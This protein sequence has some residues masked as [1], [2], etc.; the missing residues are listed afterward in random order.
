MAADAIV[1]EGYSSLDVS[2]L[3]GDDVPVAVGPGRPVACGSINTGD[4]FVA[5]VA[6][7]GAQTGLAQAVRTAERAHTEQSTL[8]R[9]ADR[10]VALIVVAAVVLA[11]ITLLAWLS[12]SG[13]VRDAIFAATAVLLVAAPGALA[14]SVSTPMRVG[15]GRGI[16][17]GIVI[18]RFSAV[19]NSRRVDAVVADRSLE[20]NEPT[21]GALSRHLR[22]IQVESIFMGRAGMDEAIRQ[23]RARRFCVALALDVSGRVPPEGTI[24]AQAAVGVAVGAGTFGPV[25]GADITLARRDLGAVADGFAL[26]QRIW[27]TISGNL[28]FTGVYHVIVLPCAIAGV[29]H[30]L[31][32]CAVG[33]TAGTLVVLNSLRL[34]R[35]QLSNER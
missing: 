20:H 7:V 15:V 34:R 8:R 23:L 27:R 32:A 3:T 5:R 11:G 16:Q 26:S 1:L 13:D 22:R 17:L 24:F 18:S 9:G 25:P 29:L 4:R 30:P 28:A 12:L 6:R 35:F 21:N 2:A 14:M 19:R 10:G 33:G 31:A